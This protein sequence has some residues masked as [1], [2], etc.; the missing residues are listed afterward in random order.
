MA[1]RD[2]DFESPLNGIATAYRLREGI[3]RFFIT[4]INNAAASASA[5]SDIA[6]QW[7][8]IAGMA[9][10]YNHVPGGSNVLYMDG[11]AAFVRYPGEHPVTRAFATLIT[12]A[13]DAL[14]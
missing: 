2:W 7:D 10:M 5:Q 1:D 8:A 14:N 6:I 4:D 3:E 12:D 9:G 13:G 11:H